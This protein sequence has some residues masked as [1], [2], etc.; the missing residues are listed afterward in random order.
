MQMNELTWESNPPQGPLARVRGQPLNPNGGHE[1]AV[2][3]EVVDTQIHLLNSIIV[4]A[5]ASRVGPRTRASGPCGVF[6]HV[7]RVHGTFS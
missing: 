1:Q 6:Y 2:P 3:A 4:S 7:R 5:P